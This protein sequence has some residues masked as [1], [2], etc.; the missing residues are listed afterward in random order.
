[1]AKIRLRPTLFIAFTTIVLIFIVSGFLLSDAFFFERLIRR[2]NITTPEEAFAFVNNNTGRTVVVAQTPPLGLG[3][4]PPDWNGQIEYS[5]REMLTRQKYLWCDQS[6]ILLATIVRELGYDTRLVD[7][8]GDD[9]IS[10]HTL[11]EV[12]QQGIWK[13]YDTY[14]EW[15]GLTYQD[16]VNAVWLPEPLERRKIIGNSP[17]IVYRPYVGPSWIV[18]NNFY[19]KRLSLWKSRLQKK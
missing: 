14:Y 19:V 3:F 17:R 4:A 7:F 8:V 10:H 11:L 13:T 12:K 2:N 16:I 15:Q 5:P 18:R 6:A 1:M 9:G